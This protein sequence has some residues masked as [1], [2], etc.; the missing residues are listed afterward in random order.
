MC[1][2]LPA[3]GRKGP[4]THCTCNYRGLEVTRCA[5]LGMEPSLP[6]KQQALTTESSLY[7]QLLVFLMLVFLTVVRYNFSSVLTYISL[8]Y[9]NDLV[10][11][12]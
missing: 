10:H 3:A 6:Q 4:Q 11:V 9:K 2:H 1:V 8:V 12:Y 5:K 7:S